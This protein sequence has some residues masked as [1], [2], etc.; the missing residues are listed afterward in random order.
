MRQDLRGRGEAL[1][2]DV[3]AALGTI[4]TRAAAVRR[5]TPPQPTRRGLRRFTELGD[6]AWLGRRYLEEGASFRE[7]AE[8]IGCSIR[9]V[10]KALAHA[11]IKPRRQGHWVKRSSETESTL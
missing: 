5:L 1:P 10:R 9:A 4:R 6:H 7:L 2:V 8:E 3:E 11:Q